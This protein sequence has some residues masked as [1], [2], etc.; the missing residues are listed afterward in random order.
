MFLS[1]LQVKKVRKD[2]NEDKYLVSIYFVLCYNMTKK[3]GFGKNWPVRSNQE[4]N[5]YLHTH[6]LFSILRL[7]FKKAN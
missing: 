3:K 1:L 2:E 4:W 7:E 6:S 5:I